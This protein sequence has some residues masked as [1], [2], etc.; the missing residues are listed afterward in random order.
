MPL[1]GI[2]RSPTW[3]SDVVSSGH[4]TGSRHSIAAVGDGGRGEEGDV[5]AA[6][7]DELQPAMTSRAAAHA[8]RR[9]WLKRPGFRR[10]TT[11]PSASDL[12]HVLR[13]L[14]EPGLV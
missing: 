12:G 7:F 10:V 14:H 8:A 13:R 9:M 1:P 11:R 4:Q 6:V 5:A 2:A 3:M